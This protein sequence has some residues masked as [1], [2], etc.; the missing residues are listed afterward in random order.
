VPVD[1]HFADIGGVLFIVAMIGLV[2]LVARQLA[3]QVRAGSDPSVRVRSLLFLLYPII[4]V[5]ALA[6]YVLEINDPGQFVG[7][8]TRTDSLYFTVVTLGTVGFGDIH[9][10]SSAAEFLTMGQIVFD[11]VV[12]GLLI[13][14]ASARMMIVSPR[15]S[16]GGKPAEDALEPDDPEENASE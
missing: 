16:Q 11:L 12:I 8:S 13:S 2:G 14:I 1:G 10:S 5:F 9:P 3:K 15:P 4:A 6:Y 7:L